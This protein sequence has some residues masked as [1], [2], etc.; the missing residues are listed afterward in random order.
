MVLNA[1][2]ATEAH[3]YIKNEL[4]PK[5]FKIIF[6]RNK[7]GPVPAPVYLKKSLL[8]SANSCKCPCK[9]SKMGVPS[10]YLYLFCTMIII[11]S[12][13]SFIPTILAVIST[14]SV[15]SVNM[16]AQDQKTHVQPITTVQSNIDRMS[17]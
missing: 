4:T 10:E 13:Q 6:F 16:N 7:V 2:E 15:N 17:P 9:R 11:Y 1:M 12:V 5:I 8:A 3:F 14:S